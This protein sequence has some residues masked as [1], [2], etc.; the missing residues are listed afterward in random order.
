[1]NRGGKRKGAGRKP[2]PQGTH[3]V[4][5]TIKVAPDLRQYLRRCEN[6]TE[7]IETAL[8]RSK[9]FRDWTRDQSG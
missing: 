4:P 1:M 8:R 5:M 6:A 9:D 2:A 3:K 7:A